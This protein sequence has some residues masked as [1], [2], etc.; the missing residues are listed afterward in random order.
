M[1]NFKLKKYLRSLL[2][3]MLLMQSPW[4]IAYN[5]AA[6]VD[7]TF[8]DEDETLIE[9]RV[10]DETIEETEEYDA[11]SEQN[12]A[13]T[14]NR[15][16]KVIEAEDYFQ[17]ISYSSCEAPSDYAC[18]P[19]IESKIGEG[20]RTRIDFI[21]LKNGEISC[22][23]FKP[24]GFGQALSRE[25]ET[26]QFKKKFI[27]STCVEK[28]SRFKNI[29][30]SDQVKKLIEENEEFINSLQQQEF[31]YS[32]DYK[33]NG[34]DMFLDWA[35]V[36]DGLVTF[37]AEIFDLE[38][39]LLTRSLKTR[40]GYTVIPNE[41]VV[42]K[43]E[44]SL[45]NLWSRVTSGS[46]SDNNSF[47]EGVEIQASVRNIADAMADTSYF[48]LLDFFIKSNDLIITIVTSLGFIFIGYNVV[49]GWIVPA[50]GNKILKKDSGENNIHRG[51][52][53]IAMIFMFV[54]TESR[55]CQCR[56]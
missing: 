47:N 10:N 46:W 12:K 6:Y 22:S 53:G 34:D 15:A 24:I 33:M 41:I 16:G 36:V 11:N 56:V 31:K 9:E 30:N 23:V 44:Q 21:D 43:F 45:G 32:V 48:M 27:N 49:V 40:N 29:D 1:K 26:I 25:T 18:P 19:L 55:C 2:F 3:F 39:T 17:N 7:A 42:D 4:A 8:V 14:E 35:D 28:Y 50:I 38:Q 20:Y 37:N 13:F 54:A 5:P 51:I 52:F